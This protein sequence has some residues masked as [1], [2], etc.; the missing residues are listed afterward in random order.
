MSF[1][2]LMIRRPPRSTRTDTLFPYTT[3]FRSPAVGLGVG[4]C[5]EAPVGPVALLPLPAVIL[6]AGGDDRNGLLAGLIDAA[7]ELAVDGV[8]PARGGDLVPGA[9]IARCFTGTLSEVVAV[10]PRNRPQPG[11]AGAR[12]VP[13]TVATAPE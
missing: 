3:L 5:A 1:C 2:F 12:A 13:P 4:V 6:G 8:R 10:T 11:E 7:G 9:G